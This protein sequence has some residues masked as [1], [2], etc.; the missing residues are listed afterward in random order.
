MQYQTCMFQD[1]DLYILLV[2]ELPEFIAYAY[3]IWYFSR[4][5]FI[6]IFRRK[7][8]CECTDGAFDLTV[9]CAIVAGI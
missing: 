3:L 5:L 4:R 7:R 9:S 2:T 1:A 6:N 8:R